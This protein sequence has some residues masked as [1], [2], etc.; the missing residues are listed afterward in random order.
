MRLQMTGIIKQP[1]CQLLPNQQK[2]I[3]NEALFYQNENYLYLILR[4]LLYGFSWENAVNV[5]DHFLNVVL[6]GWPKP[7]Q[8]I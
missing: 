8:Q 2:H 3:L 5:T 6:A 1:N 7:R 4:I